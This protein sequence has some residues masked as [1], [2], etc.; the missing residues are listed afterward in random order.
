LLF[1]PA[2]EPI[3]RAGFLFQARTLLSQLT[4]NRAR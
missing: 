2:I 4:E 1:S 3:S